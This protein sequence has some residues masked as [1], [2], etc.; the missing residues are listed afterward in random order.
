MDF[1]NFPK[2]IRIV[3]VGPRDGLQNEK[4][5]VETALKAKFIENLVASGHKT[6]EVTSFVRPDRMPQM[7]DAKELYPLVSHL[8]EN[9]VALPC[10]VPNLKGLEAAIDL[11]VKEVA[12]FTASSDSFNKK[13]INATIS[14]SFERITPVVKEAIAAGMKVRGYVSTA[15][16]CPYEGYV[17]PHKVCEVALHLDEL[18]C[19]EISLGD[20]VGTGSP[21]SVHQT[22]EL[23]LPA[24]DKKKVALHFHDTRGTALTNI[25]VGLQHGVTVFDASAGGLGG[26]PYALGATGNVATEDLVYLCHTLGIETGVDLKKL[27]HASEEILNFLGKKTTSKFLQAYIN[28]ER[29]L[30]LPT[31]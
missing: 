20:T 25:L 24:L 1:K 22:L 7:A 29:N 12:V 14:Q 5:T 19:Y 16:G 4:Q 3:E 15:F 9:G 21:L 17:D 26:C 2:K 18:G 10:L 8:E 11:G 30:Y 6:V 13:N 27:S 23:I 28:G 31:P